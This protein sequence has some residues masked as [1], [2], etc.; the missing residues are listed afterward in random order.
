MKERER[1]RKRCEGC[2]FTCEAGIVGR[3]LREAHGRVEFMAGYGD[4]GGCLNVDDDDAQRMDPPPKARD[5][6]PNWDSD[7]F[8]LIILLRI[9]SVIQLCDFLV[10]RLGRLDWNIWD[11]K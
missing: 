11:L 8:Y 6:P 3:G 9:R 7:F 5:P 1:E 2:E 10:M 4:A